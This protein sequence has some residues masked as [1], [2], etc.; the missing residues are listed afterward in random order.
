MLHIL[1]LEGR[2]SDLDQKHRISWDGF[3]KQTEMPLYIHS[4]WWH[5]KTLLFIGE[6][7]IH[8]LKVWILIES[9]P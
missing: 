9:Y 1:L 8:T 6:L 3:A 7:L 2:K 5:E 4:S